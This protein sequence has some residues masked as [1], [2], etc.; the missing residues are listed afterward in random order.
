MPQTRYLA[1]SLGLPPDWQAERYSTTIRLIG[2]CGAK[3]NVVIPY[4]VDNIHAAL[5]AACA[6]AIKDYEDNDADPVRSDYREG[7]MPH[8][9]H[10]GEARID[11][12]LLDQDPR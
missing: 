3:A 6:Q 8:A 5:V 11:P 12:R 7:A 9:S 1:E 4:G 10:D 2:P